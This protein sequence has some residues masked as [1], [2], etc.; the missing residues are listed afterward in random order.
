MVVVVAIKAALILIGVA[1]AL[2]SVITLV[3]RTTTPVFSVVWVCFGAVII[4]TGILI[5][6]HNWASIIG[7]PTLICIGIFIVVFIIF[8]WFITKQINESQHKF[9]EMNIQMTLI[10]DENKNLSEQLEKA[11]QK[12]E[13]AEKQ[14]SNDK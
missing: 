12:L 3:K 14:I 11:T 2:M 9:Q 13:E 5:E 8:L 4:L 10:R 6:P 7:I 1:V